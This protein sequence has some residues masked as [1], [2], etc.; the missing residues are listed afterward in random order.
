[1]TTGLVTPYVMP[2]RSDPTAK[3]ASVLNPASFPSRNSF[4]SLTS[5]IIG[6]NP[7]SIFCTINGSRV[8]TGLSSIL[9]ACC[10]ICSASVAR[11]ASL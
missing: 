5:I 9:Y 3:A 7:Q 4:V 10:T 6:I 1:M 11:V 2:P 8:V